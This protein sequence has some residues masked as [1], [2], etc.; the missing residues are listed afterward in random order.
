MNPGEFMQKQLH[1]LE[2]W[3]ECGN[4][5]QGLFQKLFFFAVN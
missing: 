4:N 2:I 3:V 1:C 5:K